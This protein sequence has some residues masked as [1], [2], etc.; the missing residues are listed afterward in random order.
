VLLWPHGDARPGKPS[1]AMG[2]RTL[3]ATVVAD[4]TVRCAGPTRQACRRV[5]VRLDGGRRAAITTGP[6]ASTAALETGAKIR[7]QRVDAPPGA[8][9]AEPYSLV[10]YDRRGALV[11]AAAI[12]ALLVVVITRTR[13]LLAL[14]GLAISL[15]VVTKFIVPALLAGES[16]LLVALVG[17]LAVM[18]TR[19]TSTAARA[20][21]RRT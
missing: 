17:A 15:L 11:W 7:V 14:G 5:T 6:V 4:S 9:N 12:F 3:G 13:G 19:R 20:S 2:G 1:Q 18:R 8:R 10:G 16:G 21:Y